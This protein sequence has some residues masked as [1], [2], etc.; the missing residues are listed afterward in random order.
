MFQTPRQME[1]RAPWFFPVPDKRPSNA[2]RDRVHLYCCRP[3]LILRWLSPPFSAKRICISANTYRGQRHRHQEGTGLFHLSA[4][5]TVAAA[6]HQ[7]CRQASDSHERPQIRR[8]FGQS[9]FG[10]APSL[11]LELVL[12]TS[13]CGPFCVANLIQQRS[14]ASR[15]DRGTQVDPERQSARILSDATPRTP[16]QR[17]RFDVPLSDETQHAHH[18]GCSQRPTH[19]TD[20]ASY[21]VFLLDRRNGT[22]ASLT[23]RR[24]GSTGRAFSQGI[25]PRA[26]SAAGQHRARDRPDPMSSPALIRG[27]SKNQGDRRGAY[28]CVPH[29]EG[30]KNGPSRARHDAQSCVKGHG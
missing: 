26:G 4:P 2:P 22:Y 1:P 30:R 28:P 16:I 3:K 21:P 24:S 13:G 18:A 11:P 29:R 27:P 19:Q 20:G 10:T 6:G 15:W 5:V 9:G 17:R 25:V 7:Q 8:L 12:A 23:S 14:A